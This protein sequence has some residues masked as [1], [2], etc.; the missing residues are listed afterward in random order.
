MTRQTALRSLRVA[1]GGMILGAALA[2]TLFGWVGLM[3]VHEFGALVGGSL[4]F[5]ASVKHIV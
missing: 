5:A 1:A 2:G 3:G 4:G